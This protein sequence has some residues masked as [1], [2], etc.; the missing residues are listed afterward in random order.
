M[1]FTC[2]AGRSGKPGGGSFASA[3]SRWRCAIGWAVY[4]VIAALVVAFAG[5]AASQPAA[6]AAAP[7]AAVDAHALY[8]THCAS[9]H[10][11]DRFG[12]MGPALLPES[13]GRLRKPAAAETIAKGRAATQMPAFADKLKAFA[14]IVIDECFVVSDIKIIQ[15]AEGLFVSMPSKK[16]K[17]GMFRD[18]AHPLSSETRKQLDEAILAEY[19]RAVEE[20]GGPEGSAAGASRAQQI[21]QRVERIGVEAHAQH[22]FGVQ[23][24]DDVVGLVLPHRQA[25]MPRPDHLG[26]DLLQP[27]ARAQPPEAEGALELVDAPGNINCVGA[28]GAAQ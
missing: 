13:L 17:N 25:R 10:G 20:R 24:A 4:L 1:K 21:A 2:E 23:H 16:R 28:F 5:A 27:L 8:A 11:A 9:C 14:S 18:I 12:L 22:V 7:P 3:V 19:N 15:G 6:P 26:D